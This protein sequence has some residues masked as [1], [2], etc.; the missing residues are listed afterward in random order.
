MVFGL[1]FPFFFSVFL[2]MRYTT[3]LL[4]TSRYSGYDIELSLPLGRGHQ[5]LIKSA[6][7]RTHLK[8]GFTEYL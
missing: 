2:I 4:F 5:H 3:F 8:F 1:S 6:T 7:S